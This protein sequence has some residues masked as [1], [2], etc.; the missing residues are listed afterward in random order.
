M[1]KVVSICCSSVKKCHLL[2][3]LIRKKL[4]AWFK[5]EINKFMWVNQPFLQTNMW[6]FHVPPPVGTLTPGVTGAERRGLL[7]TAGHREI[8]AIPPQLALTIKGRGSLEDSSFNQAFVW[9]NYIWMRDPKTPPPP[10]SKTCTKYSKQPFSK[11][12]EC[13]DIGH[14]Y[15][16]TYKPED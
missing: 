1:W 2:F 6:P 15:R 16:G 9:A 13:T 14:T 7:Y 12:A 10:Q 11:E 4:P 8:M 3:V 5:S